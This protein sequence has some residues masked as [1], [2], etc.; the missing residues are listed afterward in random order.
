MT[1]MAPRSRRI[2][3]RTRLGGLTAA[4]VLVTVALASLASYYAVR[5]QLL[6]QVDSTLQNELTSLSPDG[7]F[8]PNLAAHMLHRYNSSVGQVN[9]Q[10]G[11]IVYSPPGQTPLPFS[12]SEAALATGAQR[13]EYRTV[14]VDGQPYRVIEV[15]GTGSNAGLPV[16]IQIAQPLTDLQ[17]TLRDLRLILWLVAVGG[18]ALAVVLGYVIGRT[19]MRPIARL[20][21]AAE[22][23]AATQDLAATIEEQGDDELARLARSFNSML[24][25]L[26]ASRAQQ[27]KLISDAGHELRTPL[28]SLRTNIEVLMRMP[29]LPAADRD[30]LV[31]DVNAQL[32][33]MTTLIGDVVDL[34]RADEQQ[35][36]AIEVRFDPIVQ[37]ALDRARRRAPAVTIEANITPGSIRAHPALLER[38]ILNVIDNAVKWSPPGAVVFV[39]LSRP[40]P[41]VLDV[42]DQGP[43]IA[44][45]DLPHVFDRFYRSASARALPGSGLGLSI[46]RQVIGDHGG[47]VSAS[48]PPGGGTLVHIELPTVAETEPER[49][50]SP[51]PP[52]SAGAPTGPWSRP[53]RLRE[54]DEE[55]AHAEESQT[56]AHSQTAAPE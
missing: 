17:H 4:A 39:S 15:G 14:R 22:H 26:A 24:K 11:S 48:S 20:T 29:D 45:N 33:E 43:G 34:A 23:V 13:I 52:P 37:N 47:T 46:V 44:P 49:P 25:A 31:A 16:V 10:D 54:P 2:S 8:D 53:A 1:P 9:G 56:P 51:P 40:G 38:A 28:T 36:D 18:A 32:T 5:H 50:P 35:S 7:Q 3:F 12:S 21:S 19:T 41:W 27:V 6:S 30:E 55:R 42:R